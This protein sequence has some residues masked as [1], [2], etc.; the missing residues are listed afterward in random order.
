MLTDYKKNSRFNINVSGIYII[1]IIGAEGILRGPYS[2]QQKSCAL[3]HSIYIIQST[4]LR[5]RRFLEHTD[6][7]ALGS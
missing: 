4:L 5:P 1:F 2:G 6:L 7:D 3:Q